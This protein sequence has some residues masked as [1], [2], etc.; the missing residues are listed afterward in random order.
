MQSFVCIPPPA[1]VIIACAGRRRRLL[2]GYQVQ[3]GVRWMPGLLQAMK[4]V[5]SCENPR[6][7]A[8]GL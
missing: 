6:V 4:D 7:G 1:A 3:K 8:N 2:A 5:I